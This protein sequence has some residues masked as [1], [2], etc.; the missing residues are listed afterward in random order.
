[1]IVS[2]DACSG[3]HT[4]RYRDRADHSEGS[5]AKQLDKIEVDEIPAVSEADLC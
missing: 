2:I 4:G 5:T 3:A 1:M